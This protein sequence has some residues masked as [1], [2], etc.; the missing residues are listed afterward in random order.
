[1]RE[2]YWGLQRRDLVSIATELSK[3]YPGAIYPASPIEGGIG[4]GIGNDIDLRCQLPS[5]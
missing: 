1:M 5:P 3:W 4:T 2:A